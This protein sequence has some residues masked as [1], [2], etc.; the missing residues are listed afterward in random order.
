MGFQGCRQKSPLGLRAGG[1]EGVSSAIRDPPPSLN[2][3]GGCRQSS[4]CRRHAGEQGGEEGEGQ[5][6]VFGIQPQSPLTTHR[7]METCNCLTRPAVSRSP[8]PV[9]QISAEPF[10][11]SHTK[12][13]YESPVKT[14]LEYKAFS[15]GL[16]E[17]Q[18][19]HTSVVIPGGS[20]NS[21]P[22]CP[23]TTKL[24]MTH[25]PKLPKG[26][27]TIYVRGRV[28]LPQCQQNSPPASNPRSFAH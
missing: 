14:L 10:I 8:P 28:L 7:I 22:D 24:K 21:C 19:L 9:S 11:T 18:L 25:E 16:A 2:N 12:N 13:T 23:E 4:L 27:S 15:L 20:Q 1:F 5:P 26:V 3:E 6:P 17:T